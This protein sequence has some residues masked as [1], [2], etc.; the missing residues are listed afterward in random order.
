M[1]KRSFLRAWRHTGLDHDGVCKSNRSI[2]LILDLHKHRIIV[3]I[4]SKKGGNS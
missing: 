3:I 4:V 2:M 1:S